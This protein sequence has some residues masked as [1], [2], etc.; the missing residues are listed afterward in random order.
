MK[1]TVI[2]KEKDIFENIHNIA[3]EILEKNTSMEDVVLMGIRTGGAYLAT[4]LQKA[5]NRL[6]VPEPLLGVLDITLYR[7]DWT[8]IGPIPV[9][10]KTKIPFSIDDKTVILVDDVSQD[11]TE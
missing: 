5:I 10:K 3:K 8:R 9:V 4:R 2:L 11:Q 7:D 1:K 6:N